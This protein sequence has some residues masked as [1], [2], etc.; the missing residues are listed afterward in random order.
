MKNMKIH[1]DI[2]SKNIYYVSM[3]N[4]NG[5]ISMFGLFK[6]S[7]VKGV[8]GKEAKELIANEKKL[9]IIDIRTA[10]EVAGGKLP[11]A[12][13]IDFYGSSFQKEIDKLDREGVYLVYCAAGGRS[14]SAV[15][16][17]ERMDFKNIYELKGGYGSY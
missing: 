4:T 6:K 13:H 7:N 5:V 9:V 3:K 8:N 1:I 16:L 17:M 14:K 2:F 12:K 10:N 11:K 15:G